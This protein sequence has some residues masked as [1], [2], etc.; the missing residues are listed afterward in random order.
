VFGT[1]L[2]VTVT[3]AAGNPVPGV[4]VTFIA[5]A[6]GASGTFSNGM[7]TIA[8][9]TDS[10]GIATAGTFT[11]NPTMGPYTV[12]AAAAGQS[13]DF[14]LTNIAGPGP[15][16]HFAVSAP[17][18]ATA[19]TPVS[20][21]VT[22]LDASAI[23][24]TG[25]TG[26]VHFT[27]TDGSATLPGNYGFV[28][29]D[30]GIHTFTSGATLNTVGTQTITATDTVTASIYGTSGTITVSST[31]PTTAPTTVPTTTAV[32]SATAVTTLDTSGNDDDDTDTTI[33]IMTVTVNIGGDSKAWQAIVTGTKLSDLIVTG[34]I[35]S[36]F[37]SNFTTP[38]GIVYQ[39]INL[40]PARYD[41]ITKS[42][43]N[44]TVPQSWLDENH[45]APKSIVLYHQT[46]KGWEAL[47]TT[48]LSTK[49]GSVFFSAQSTGFSLFAIAGTPTVLTPPVTVATPDLVSTPVQ[50]QPPA[51][52][53]VTKVP[54]TTQ[55]T[56][57]PAASPQPA[58]PSPLL[59]IVL[60]IAAI[61][62]LAGGGFMARRWWIRRQNP[63]L[64]REYDQ[65]NP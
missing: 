24:A 16:T 8:V 1:D 19:G 35:Q 27:S 37:G 36:G 51:P 32:S 20:Y 6:S 3:D 63:A 61:G 23:T 53:A 57:P 25:Y 47:P 18:M 48:V 58:A 34:T 39:Y 62:I 21:T 45:I 2:S 11:A 26:T 59:N 56:A 28:A 60:V 50:V 38:P 30:A 54:V 52:A 55:T 31:T 13:A 22:A 33:P 5:P 65:D 40:V 49:D 29:G 7:N 42:V 64:F 44:F 46:A 9:T 41:T 17:T 12:T 4:S 10:S 14:S 43:I 15:A